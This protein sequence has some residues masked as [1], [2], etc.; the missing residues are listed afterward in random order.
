MPIRN[1]RAVG[2]KHNIELSDFWEREEPIQEKAAEIKRRMQ[3]LAD[4]DD[5]L[6]SLLEDLCDCQDV[7][8]F[9]EVWTMIYDWADDHLVWINV[10]ACFAPKQAER[11]ADERT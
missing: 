8:A 11:E 10:H 2:W 5:E 4:F 9:D 6:N 3:K 1:G 7:E